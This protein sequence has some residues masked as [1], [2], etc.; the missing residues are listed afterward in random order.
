MKTKTK[1]EGLSPEEAKE[2]IKRRRNQLALHSTIYYVYDTNIISDSMYDGFS[3]DLV[4]LQAL[5]PELS[6]EVEYYD[7]FKDWDGSTGFHLTHRLNFHHKALYMI[8]LHE[9]QSR[10]NK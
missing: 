1:L 2:L 6:K 5:Y 8:R 9:E 7:A 10:R 3:E 4:K